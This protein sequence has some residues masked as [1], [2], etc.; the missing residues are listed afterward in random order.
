MKRS[1]QLFVF[2]SAGLMTACAYN[3]WTPDPVSPGT[4][5]AA[6]SS[7]KAAGPAAAATSR[8]S[9]GT[10]RQTDAPPES[11]AAAAVKTPQ[12]ATP[13]GR[14]G[15]DF[16]YDDGLYHSK[17]RLAWKHP[18][19]DHPVQTPAL[20]NSEKS[21]LPA[22]TQQSNI[23]VKPLPFALIYGSLVTPWPLKKLVLVSGSGEKLE[24]ELFKI[25]GKPETVFLFTDPAPGRWFLHSIHLAA[26][27]G[28]QTLTLQFPPDRQLVFQRPAVSAV[29]S[30]RLLVVHR[31]RLDTL[32]QLFKG[33]R[34]TA[35]VRDID[36]R[37]LV[38]LRLDPAK[39]LNLPFLK[40]AR[41]NL[42]EK[43]LQEM[44]LKAVLQ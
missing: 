34:P 1:I 2:C 12:R 15:L 19:E 29:Y 10:A 7:S 24:A 23:T 21:N 43:T 22:A 40:A 18:Q 36:F 28:R 5:A 13:T 32:R 25:D 44:H 41:R 9:A 27:N 17:P 38:L 4:A 42:P 33:S 20:R 37:P 30:G 8:A 14:N 16:S 35:F 6:G 26:T 3:R 11:P 39:K 31:D